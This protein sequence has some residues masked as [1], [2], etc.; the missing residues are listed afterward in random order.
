MKGL[1]VIMRKFKNNVPEKGTLNA[2]FFT[3]GVSFLSVAAIYAFFRGIC[4]EKLK[5]ISAEKI[6]KALMD[7]GITSI[8]LV[9]MFAVLLFEAILARKKLISITSELKSYAKDLNEKKK[10]TERDTKKGILEEC[11]KAYFKDKEHSSIGPDI[12]EYIN[13]QLIFDLVHKNITDQIANAMTGLGILGTFIGLTVGLKNFD[14]NTAKESIET[15]MGGIKTAYYTSIFGVLISLV[16]NFFYQKDMEKCSSALETFLNEYSITEKDAEITFYEKMLSYNDRQANA[17]ENFANTLAPLLEGTVKQILNSTLKQY[18]E[19]FDKYVKDTIKSQHSILKDIVTDFMTELTGTLDVKFVN[20]GNSIDNMCK[21]QNGA[22]EKLSAVVAEFKEMSVNMSQLN[23]DLVE[24][25]KIRR[26]SENRMLKVCKESERYVDRFREYSE[27]VNEWT[28][29]IKGG[30]KQLMDKALE[31][32]EGTESEI[33]DKLVEFIGDFNNRKNADDEKFKKCLE[34]FETADESAKN[35]VA[36]V[37]GLKSQS[38]K[39]I[40]ELN[41]TLEDFEKEIKKESG[42]SNKKISECFEKLQKDYGENV[43][44]LNDYRDK[45]EDIL[46]LIK[47]SISDLVK[48]SSFHDITKTAE[49][50][51]EELKQLNNKNDNALAAVKRIDEKIKNID[52]SASR[53]EL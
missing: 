29:E 46:N 40:L 38:N 22:V 8:F 2:S 27:T 13:E 23:S 49:R 41:K 50:A 5:A 26:E 45:N 39:N 15:L 1:Q 30:Y 52:V 17:L 21:W 35:I 31:K 9:F 6:I 53:S 25:E 48:E 12:S 44:R 18:D 10:L 32:I 47:E 37:D 24:E 3:L 43:K 4:F 20:L 14:I 11:F 34:K 19:N 33:K 51:L 7:D 16:Y 36:A 28:K 42:N